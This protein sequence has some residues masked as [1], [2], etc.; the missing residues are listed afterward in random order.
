[1]RS[2]NHLGS[3]SLRVGSLSLPPVPDM[4]VR[5]EPMTVWVKLGMPRIK[6]G[7]SSVVP[8]SVP[9]E[10]MCASSKG[11]GTNTVLQSL[12]V[13]Q[14][15]WNRWKSRLEER[16][17]EQQ[18]ALTLV[19]HVRYRRVL[20]RRVFDTWLLKACELQE[21][22]MGE[23]RYVGHQREKWRKLVQADLH[24]R[25]TLL[26]KTLAAWKVFDAWLMF[27]KG[28]QEKEGG[29]E[30]GTGIPHTT[31]QR[32]GV[33]WPLSNT[34][35]MKQLQGQLHAQHQLK[36]I[37]SAL[38]FYFHS[39]AFHS[40][41]GGEGEHS[42]R[43]EM[44]LQREVAAELRHI[45]QQMQYYY[46][47]KQELK[48]CQ[49]QAQILQQWLERSTGAGARGVQEELGQLQVRINTLSKAQPRERHHVQSLLARLREI[50]LALDL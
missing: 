16:E 15:F 37:N 32:E 46:S 38:L 29:I 50:Q 6:E 24:Y 7:I 17:E 2:N 42:S 27:A 14:K 39:C 49:Q 36:K 28:Q 11:R 4:N 18:Q 12:M 34:G 1:M 8:Y 20:M 44:V 30:K 41:A 33:T 25:H 47:R 31:S 45:Q 5:P 21:Y 23:K 19:A 9:G 48:S 13:L 43:E 40:A 26:S 35:G 22:R 3:E 10:P